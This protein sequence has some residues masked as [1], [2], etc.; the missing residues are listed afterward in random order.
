MIYF[1][2]NKFDKL[3]K[4]DRFFERHKLPKQAFKK[5]QKQKI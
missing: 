2:A 4:M 5:N 1:Q 3:D